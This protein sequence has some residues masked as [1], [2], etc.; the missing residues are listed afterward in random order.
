MFDK[1]INRWWTVLAGAMGCSVGAGMISV[2]ALGV[3]VKDIADEFAWGRSYVSAG[4]TC[5]FFVSGLGSVAL[6][7]LMARWPMRRVVILFVSLFALALGLVAALP[8]SLVLFC[9][10]FALMGFFGSAATPM[11]YAVAISRTFDRNRGL[12]LALMVSGSGF[13][14]L[15]LP[16]YANELR[17]AYG[18]RIGYIGVGTLVALVS[19]IALIFFFRNP[20]GRPPEFGKRA[21]SIV[22]VYRSG[23]TFWLISGSIFCISIALVGATSNMVPILT[24]RGMPAD[25]AAYILGLSGA[26]SWISRLGVGILVDRMHAKYVAVGIFIIGLLGLVLL[27]V[28]GEGLGLFAAAV[29]IGIGIGAEADL[30]TYLMSR[31]FA[32]E[33]LSRAL[34]A[35]WMFWAWGIGIGVFAGS[36]SYDLTG[37]YSA[38]LYAFSALA[39]VSII[40]AML[41]GTYRFPPEHR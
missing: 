35:A 21:T 8:K 22:E 34:G 37:N 25:K 14:A 3:F 23:A 17:E 38:A 41:L 36:L 33:A 1:P 26:A 4:L 20:P 11:P 39:V 40:A 9:I 19:L 32:P 18:W 16:T 12:A 31:Y 6:G 5:F 24:D 29:C 13:G 2:Y 27:E 10:L 7:S 28:G 30:L 15:L